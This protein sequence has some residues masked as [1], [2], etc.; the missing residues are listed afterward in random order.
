MN[1]IS[2][3]GVVV[4]LMGRAAANAFILLL[5]TEESKL[6]VYG[7]GRISDA[8]EHYATMES[9][10]ELSGQD[11]VLVLG[12]SLRELRQGYPNYHA[13]VEDFLI[14]L[15]QVCDGRIHHSVHFG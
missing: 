1:L 13:D 3:L 8:S 4:D 12:H 5:D 2:G 14:A 7:F 6:T 15:R 9:R 11:A 10:A